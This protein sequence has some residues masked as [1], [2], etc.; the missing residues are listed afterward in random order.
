MSKSR[1]VSRAASQRRLNT[2]VSIAG[3][4]DDDDNSSRSSSASPTPARPASPEKPEEPAPTPQPEPLPQPQVEEEEVPL[5]VAP[6]RVTPAPPPAEA[7]RASDSPRALSHAF[8]LRVVPGTLNSRPQQQGKAAGAGAGGKGARAG[9]QGAGPRLGGVGAKSTGG[10]L[11]KAG[12]TPTQGTDSGSSPHPFAAVQQSATPVWVLAPG[13]VKPS[14]PRRRRQTDSSVDGRPSAYGGAQA[15]R[16]PLSGRSGGMPASGSIV[17]GNGGGGRGSPRAAPPHLAPLTTRPSGDPTSGQDTPMAAHAGAP[18]PCPEPTPGM[19]TSLPHLAGQPSAMS[20]FTASMVQR[21]I[22]LPGMDILYPPRAKNPSPLALVT[23]VPQLGFP[24]SGTQGQGLGVAGIG[25]APSLLNCVAESDWAG[26]KGQPGSPLAA[27]SPVHAATAAAAKQRRATLL[28]G[29]AAQSVG[30]NVSALGLGA[31]EGLRQGMAQDQAAG[32]SGAVRA[33]RASV[34][35][36]DKLARHNAASAPAIVCRTS[37]PLPGQGEA[38]PEDQAGDGSPTHGAG[39]GVGRSAGAVL[40]SGDASVGPRSGAG[41]GNGA[42]SG[43]GGSDD[44]AMFPSDPQVLLDR[45]AAALAVMHAAGGHGHLRRKSLSVEGSANSAPAVGVAVTTARRFS[46]PGIAAVAG[47]GIQSGGGG[48]AGVAG[49]DGASSGAMGAPGLSLGRA[50][51]PLPDLQPN[52][53]VPGPSLAALGGKA[54]RPSILV[55]HSVVGVVEGGPSPQAQ[56][57]G[58]EHLPQIHKSVRF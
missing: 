33:R 51:L 56:G 29:G 17:I 37:C 39:P 47:N 6:I 20:A 30:L 58:G 25:A 49:S 2:R 48:G 54:R 22:S 18:S 41:G 36:L 28:F 42:N 52:P 45:A 44:D 57:E 11:A 23:R 12:N 13:P 27:V 31:G 14:A 53:A 15:A 55:R 35:I 50:S 26:G 24:G 7:P 8:S 16:G 46:L 34:A 38:Q 10:A 9:G 5:P 21:S 40:G 32:Q 3:V 4:R 1:A 43:A 19:V